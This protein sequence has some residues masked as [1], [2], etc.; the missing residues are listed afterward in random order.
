MHEETLDT[1]TKDEYTA[2][3]SGDKGKVNDDSTSSSP[4][5]DKHL[6]DKVSGNIGEHRH[7]VKPAEQS[8]ANIGSTSKKRLIKAIGDHSEAQ[9]HGLIGDGPSPEKSNRNRTK[10]KKIKL[11]FDEE[12]ET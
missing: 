4:D 8:Q 10:R 5:G 11:S 12:A 7:D 1:I 9:E 3:L 2:L 6:D